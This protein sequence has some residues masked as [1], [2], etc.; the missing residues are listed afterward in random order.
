MDW[1]GVIPINGVTVLH[2]DLSRTDMLYVLQTDR[3]VWPSQD[4]TPYMLGILQSCTVPPSPYQRQQSCGCLTENQQTWM[5]PRTPY[6]PSDG[7]TGGAYSCTAVNV[8]TGQNQTASHALTVVGMWEDNTQTMKHSRTTC[9]FFLRFFFRRLRLLWCCSICHHH[10]RWMLHFY[11]R[12]K[13]NHT[14]LSDT[15]EKVNVYVI[16]TQLTHT[17]NYSVF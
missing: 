1:G 15:L 4:L 11:C 2:S 5:R 16:S 13:C 9:C 14:L 12:N 7:L 6:R 3:T 10:N 17:R 8:V